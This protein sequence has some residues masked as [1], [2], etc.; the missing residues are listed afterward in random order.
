MDI[1]TPPYV[2]RTTFSMFVK[3]GH[4]P[5]FRFR[6]NTGGINFVESEVDVVIEAC[7]IVSA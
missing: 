5:F 1:D 2:M 4:I 6:N 7:I 3:N